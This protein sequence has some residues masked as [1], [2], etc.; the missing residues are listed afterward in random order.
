MH[1]NEG[2]CKKC[3]EIFDRYPHF[4]EELK[5]WF[6]AI[7]LENPDAHISC[8]GRGRIDQE[9]A[10][11]R[12]A[13]RAH[14]GQSAHNYNCAIDIFQLKDK[15]AVWEVNWFRKVV[16]ENLYPHLKWYGTPGA[17][18]NELPHVEISDW[19]MLVKNKKAV[20]VEP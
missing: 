19:P 20:L 18:Y 15:S 9:V 6:L 5:V 3:L 11:K 13:S 10:F 4:N 16:A 17:I 8:A 12:G 7:Q 2:D 1:T 14:Y